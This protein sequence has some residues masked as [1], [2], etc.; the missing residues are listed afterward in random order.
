MGFDFGSGATVRFVS[1]WHRLFVLPGGAGRV[2]IAVPG[3][4][5]ALD[6]KT[7][8]DCEAVLDCRPVSVCTVGRLHKTD[9]EHTAAGNCCGS[10]LTSTHYLH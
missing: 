10:D 4:N 2:D 7:V 6:C 5:F 9:F 3:R 1:V 8:L